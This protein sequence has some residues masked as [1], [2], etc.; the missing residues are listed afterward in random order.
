MSRDVIEKSRDN[1]NRRIRKK[2]AEKCKMFFIAS[3]SITALPLLLLPF[4]GIRI[5]SKF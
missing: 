3:P 1:K 2:T 5:F 4:L